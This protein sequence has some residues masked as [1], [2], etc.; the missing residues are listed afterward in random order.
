M[1]SCLPEIRCPI[2]AVGDQP[3]HSPRWTIIAPSGRRRGTARMSA[4]A[5]SAVSS[6]STPGVFVTTMP[7]ESALATSI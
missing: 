4:I 7:R 5:M 2:S 1:P 3:G 6:A